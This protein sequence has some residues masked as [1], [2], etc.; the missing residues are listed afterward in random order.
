MTVDTTKLIKSPE[1]TYDYD[2]KHES[3]LVTVE[4]PGV[5]SDAYE[6]HI[7][8]CGFYISA[9]T[10]DI[11]YEGKYRFFHE[12]DADAAKV[13][14]RNGT[15]SLRLPFFAPICGKQSPLDVNVNGD[16]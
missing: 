3:L 16:I 13:E 5:V 1:V 15:L 7:A 9:K 6:L 11:Q 4:L 10:A 12:V 8:L 14:F 2:H